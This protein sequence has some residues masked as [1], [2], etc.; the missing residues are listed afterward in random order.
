MV[1]A[2]LQMEHPITFGECPNVIEVADLV[3]TE[4][5]HPAGMR[6]SFH[7]HEVANI[8]VV[9][10]GRFRETV[11]HRAF[12]CRPGTVLVKPEGARHSNQYD[13]GGATTLV[14]EVPKRAQN[15][16]ELSGVF[17]ET[18]VVVSSAS[19][20]IASRLA[21][22]LR[23]EA[24]ARKLMLEGL[25]YELFGFVARMS[26]LSASRP[27][28]LDDV[29]EFIRADDTL[30]LS[31]VSRLVARHPSHVAREFQRHMGTSVGAFARRHRLD[32]AAVTLREGDDPIADVAL[33]CGFHDQSHF[34]RSFHEYSGATPAQYRGR[35]RRSQ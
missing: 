18:R 28:W 34:T 4:A 19:H 6:L 3:L 33:A 12:D 20:H 16:L 32:R 11:Q 35:F 9:L 2:T 26:R 25:A 24:P 15:R 10:R 8:A 13:D 17:C 30:S 27:L 14:V 7:E 23:G 22:E 31:D 29:A 5:R 21:S 1:P